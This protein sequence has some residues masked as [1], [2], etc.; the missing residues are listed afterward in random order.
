[1]FLPLPPSW[2]EVEIF[3][4]VLE[5]SFKTGWQKFS[6]PENTVSCG[7]APIFLVPFSKGN[8]Y[9]KVVFD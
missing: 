9:F 3:L 8:L 7:E 4:N 5:H 6:Y 2:R 1:M